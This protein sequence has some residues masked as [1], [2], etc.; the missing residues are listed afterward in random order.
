MMGIKDKLNVFKSFSR[1]ED[2]IEKV[3][4]KIIPEVAAMDDYLDMAY[5]MW[6]EDEMEKRNKK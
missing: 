4:E 3:E 6:K 2:S 1:L 5:E